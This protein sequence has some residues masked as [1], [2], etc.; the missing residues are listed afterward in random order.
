MRVTLLGHASV[1][2][3]AQGRNLLIDPVFEDPFADGML[4][5]CPSRK[6]EPGRLPRIDLVALS[7]A[8]PDHFD[9]AT[10]ARISRDSLV[11]CPKD[12]A[13]LYV[14]EKLGFR[15]V[16]AVDAGASIALG[17]QL[18]LVTTPSA[19]KPNELGFLLRSKSGTFWDVVASQPTPPVVERVRSQLGR[20]HLLLARY[21]VPD[22]NYFGVQRAGFP[23]QL[24]TAAL[25][26]AQQVA[27]DLVVP[28]SSGVR[29]AEPFDWTNP[30]LFPISP[31][32][33]LRDLGR[34]AP[35]LR[36][37]VGVPG[38]VFTIGGGQVE[39]EPAASQVVRMV[40]DDA[41]RIAYDPTAPVP[42][43]TDPNLDSYPLDLLEQQ[44]STTFAELTSF[45]RAGYTT[46]PVMQEHR[47]TLGSYG[48]GVVFP[49]G[50]ERWIRVQFDAAAPVIA[51]GEGV[52]RD[53]LKTLRIA[54]S[55]LTGRARCERG[56]PFTGGLTR[57]TVISPA[58]LVDGQVA[59]EPREPTDLLMHYLHVRPPGPLHYLRKALDFRMARALA[60]GGHR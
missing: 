37:S 11:V 39:R 19:T 13:I 31:E 58:S 38:D 49:G 3:E 43:L 16:H 60:R 17:D 23:G 32:R 12:T 25:A 45:V 50:R 48:L 1:L 30:F 59:V 24:L 27:P 5:S 34:A 42:P 7:D 46:D 54:A 44:V 14:L 6:V 18:A 21:A 29:F 22:L 36:G 15:K 33:F 28:G 2:V 47:R 56:Y 53:A 51:S 8:R 57:N 10:L 55:V 40:E 20:V 4:A 35:T 9:V 52:V 41:W 26:L